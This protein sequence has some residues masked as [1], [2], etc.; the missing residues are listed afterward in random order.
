M[1]NRSTVFKFF[2]ILFL[3]SVVCLQ[4]LSMKQSDRLFER[5]VNL[6]KKVSKLPSNFGTTQISTVKQ[7]SS[8]DGDW[9]I[10]RIPTEP[11]TLNPI[12][13]TDYYKAIICDGTSSTPPN[14]FESLAVSDP[15]TGEYLPL[16]AE[17][18]EIAPDGLSIEFTLRDNIW[19]SDNE[20]V[21]VDDVIFSFELLKNPKI[22]NLHLA[23]YFEDVVSCKKTGE[24]KVKFEMS[25]VYF[26]MLEITGTMLII[27]QHIYKF[28]KPEDFNQIRTDP[29][30]SGPYVFDKWEIGN[31]LSLSRNENYWGRKPHI[32]KQVYKVIS[33]DLAAV[34]AMR[35]GELDLVGTIP[36]QYIKL[37]KDP[38]LLKDYTPI[39]YWKASGGYTYIGWNMDTGFFNDRRVRQAMTMLIDR[40]SIRD[41][42]YK[43]LA[44]IVTGPFYHNSPQY[45]KEITPWPFDPEQAGKLLTEA[46]WI[47]TNGDG[48]RDKDGKEFKF[49]YLM[50]SGN[51]TTEQIVKLLKDQFAKSGIELIPDTYEWSVFL[52][53]L[54][55]RDF[56]AITLGWSG[57]MESDPYQI[58]HSSQIETGGSNRIGFNNKEA[59]RLI[60]EARE[61]LDKDKRN[62]LYHQLHQILHDEQPYTFMFASPGLGFLSNRFENVQIHKLGMNPHEWYVLPENQKYSD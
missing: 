7:D 9:L 19:F 14:I 49:R 45:N 37:S 62:A 54:T 20:P 23:N 46:G 13:A 33:N 58:W 1:G 8:K 51:D 40:E 59:D 3:L 41:N 32:K 39:S 2:V 60:E 38:Q 15:D 48:I 29:I 11:A 42:I 6:E 30:G 26:K 61:T 12:T 57:A 53:K 34:S 10:R 36:E 56:D 17:S 16:L 52:Q 47:D 44:K 24:K 5:V 43:S 28:E 22:D 35:A 55:S 25:K 4:L 27:P 50:P 31:Y 21:T 18:W